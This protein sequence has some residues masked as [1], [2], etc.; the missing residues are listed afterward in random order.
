[1][2]KKR[3]WAFV[4]YPESLPEDWKE[5]LQLTGLEIAIS[6]LHDQ[7][8]NPTGDSKKAHYHI[9]LCYKGP[10]TL[11]NVKSLVCDRLGQPIPIPLDSV[12][13]Y[14]NY[15]TH[16]DNPEKAQYKESEIQTFNGF[17]S[18][19]YNALTQSQ[20]KKLII[21]LSVFIVDNDIIEYADLVQ[22]LLS[23]ELFDLFEVASTH[24]FYFNSFI[25]SRRNKKKNID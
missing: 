9:I 13:G 14:Y 18:S 21:D 7:D 3:Y 22:I 23:E 12:V 20:I 8:F 24:T 4:G 15:L 11:E 1:M 16:K 5:Q 19:K 10:T 17:D 25:T 2:T 6:P